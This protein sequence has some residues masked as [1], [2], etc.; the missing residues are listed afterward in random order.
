VQNGKTKSNDAAMQGVS[1]FKSDVRFAKF[2]EV[3]KIDPTDAGELKLLSQLKIDPNTTEAVT[4]FLAPPGA[5]IAKYNGATDMNTMVAA[6]TAATSGGCG[7]G[8]CGPS[9]CGPTK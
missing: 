7:S 8:G 1:S 6:L 5:V 4:A 9:G 3:V 2:T